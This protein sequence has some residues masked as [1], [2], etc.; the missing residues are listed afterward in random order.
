MMKYWVR[1]RP[2]GAKNAPYYVILGGDRGTASIR[3]V[4]GEWSEPVA[5]LL[6]EALEA[7]R[8]TTDDLMP[9]RESTAVERPLYSWQCGGMT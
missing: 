5:R 8:L 1:E 9:R 3:R 4:W 6:A 7:E 2:A